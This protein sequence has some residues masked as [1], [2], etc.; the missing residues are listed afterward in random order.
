[1]AI[2]IE[3]TIRW[4]GYNPNDLSPSSG[5]RVW[6][7]CENCGKGRW[8]TYHAYRD[9]CKSCA[10]KKAYKNPLARKKVS[11]GVIKAHKDDPMINE[12]KRESQLRRFENLSECERQAEGARKTW[13]DLSVREK[14]IHGIKKVYDEMDDS[15]QQI[16]NHHYIYDFNDL[17]KYTIP[18]TR[19]E[20]TTIHN[21]LRAAGIEVPCINILKEN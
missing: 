19:S 21:N 4:K 10:M 7:N 1:M 20:H 16:V 15:G 2:N 3:A 5:K 17:S 11:D 6:V 9:L 18:V 8:V 13:K 12:K 14:R